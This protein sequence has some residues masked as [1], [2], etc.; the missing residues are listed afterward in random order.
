[1]KNNACALMH[2]QILEFAIAKSNLPQSVNTFQNVSPHSPFAKLVTSL[3]TEANL[4]RL[5]KKIVRWFDETKGN[6]KH[7][8]YRFAG[9]DSRGFLH[10]FMYLLRA[11]EC[12]S[13]SESQQFKLHVLAFTCLSL[14]DAVSLFCRFAIE[15]K[16]LDQLDKVCSDFFYSCALFL[17]VNP[18]VWAL[19][20]V[21][22]VHM[23]EIFTKYGVGL[24]IN[25]M[26]GREA[27]HQAIARYAQNSTFNTCWQQV[28]CHEFVALIWLQEK[29][30]NLTNTTSS[31]ETYIPN[32]VSEPN[33]CY[34]GMPATNTMCK[35]CSHR[36]RSDIVKSVREKCFRV[37]KILLGKR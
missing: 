8:E 1:M 25:S 5:A 18:T 19:G 28:F 6:R 12:K 11:I 23:R 30:H 33:F 3:K 31:K 9:K 13:N 17:H 14:H 4:S 20:H 21:V 7:F 16:H 32:R 27:K 36:F 2:C 35:Y 34:C 37:N 29:G 26:E 22:P 15:Q 10:N 24:S